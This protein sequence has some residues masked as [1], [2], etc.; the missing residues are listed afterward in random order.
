MGVNRS[1]ALVLGFFAAVWVALVA[2][3][4]LAPEIYV[5][6]MGPAGIPRAA[7]G[8]GLLAFVSGLIAVISVGVLRRW[9]WVFWVLVVAFLAGALRVPASILQLAGVLPPAGPAWYELLQALIGAVQLTIGVMLVRGYK[10]GGAWGR[11]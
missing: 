8:I 3:L 2:I 7:A 5:E 4:V 9:R 1:Q 6:T 10:R 11:F